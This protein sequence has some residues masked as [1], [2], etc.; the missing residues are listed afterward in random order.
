MVFVSVKEAVWTLS[1]V[2]APITLQRFGKWTFL[3][4]QV[5]RNRTEIL[6]LGPLVELQAS[7]LQN[8]SL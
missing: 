7:T 6:L 8:S 5:K 1:T 3:R 2:Y 4:L